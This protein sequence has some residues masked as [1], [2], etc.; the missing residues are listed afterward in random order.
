MYLLLLAG[1]HYFTNLSSFFAH[2][3]NDEVREPNYLQSIF[4]GHVE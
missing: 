3:I 4:Y 2:A 1:F